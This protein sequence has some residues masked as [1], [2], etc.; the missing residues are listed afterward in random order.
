MMSM[1]GH[2]V[3]SGAHLKLDAM[4]INEGEVDGHAAGM[5]RA[6]ARIGEEPRLR[7]L[8]PQQPLRFARTERIEDFQAIAE[9]GGK[10]DGFCETV[11]GIAMKVASRMPIYGCS[12]DIIG[13]SVGKSDNNIVSRRGNFDQVHV[14]V[15]RQQERRSRLRDT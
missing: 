1:V 12:S 15:L 7:K 10:L 14:A 2:I 11:G 8:R 4:S 13:R 3:E 9:R 6:L 5:R